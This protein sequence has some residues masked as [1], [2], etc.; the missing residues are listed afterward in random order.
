[1]VGSGLGLGVGLTSGLGLIGVLAGGFGLE[2]WVRLGASFRFCG[3]GLRNGLGH[4]REGV[5]GLGVGFM[6]WSTVRGVGG[7]GL[8]WWLGLIRVGVGV[9]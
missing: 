1:M 8:W 6:F 7:W 2:F 4:I 9:G 5:G 3:L